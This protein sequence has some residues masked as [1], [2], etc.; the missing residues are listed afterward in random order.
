MFR[1]QDTAQNET[2]WY[3]YTPSNEVETAWNQHRVGDFNARLMEQSSKEKHVIGK[4][5]YRHLTSSV[6]DQIEKQR[7]NR[8]LFT[9]F[10]MAQRMTPM[11][12]WFEKPVP[13][14]ATLGD[15]STSHF[16]LGWVN[17]LTHGQLD[18]VLVSD[19]LK[20]A[21]YTLHSWN[22]DGF[23]SCTRFHRHAR[24]ICRETQTSN[25]KDCDAEM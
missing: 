17:T 6:N 14:L 11:N 20:N 24:L 16:Q 5:I 25:R 4:H 2:V 12:T 23:W 8:Q 18:Y 19:T 15:T 9:E 13:L 10:C 22:I 1:M 7:E 3:T 21:W